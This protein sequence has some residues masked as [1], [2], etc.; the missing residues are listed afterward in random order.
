MISIIVCNHN[1]SH[2][3]PVLMQAYN[4]YPFDKDEVEMVI[5]DDNSTDNFLKYLALSMKVVEPWF[6]VRAFET[7]RQVTYNNVLADNIGVKQCR[8]DVV[9]LNPMDVIPVVDVLPIIHEEHKKTSNLYLC[10]RFFMQFKNWLKSGK[11]WQTT[12]CGASLRKESYTLLGG[13]DERF[14]G[15]CSSDVDFVDRIQKGPFIF[16]KDRRLVYVHLYDVFHNPVHEGK[17]PPR[18]GKWSAN[19]N[20]WGELDTLKEINISEMVQ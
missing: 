17:A 18:T 1:Y 9:V 4:K 10:S 13:Q 14:I 8:G 19:P 20:G 16:K 15:H 2:F 3:L 5:V 6:K 12:T 7:H 11:E